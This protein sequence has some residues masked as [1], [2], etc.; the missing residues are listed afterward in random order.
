M[1]DQRAHKSIFFKDFSISFS[2]LP[3]DKKNFFYSSAKI[4]YSCIA[5][6]FI[7]LIL[8]FSANIRVIV[9]FFPRLSN[10]RDNNTKSWYGY[11]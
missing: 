3:V 4:L 11:K 6:I 5:S 9:K 2:V 7:F 8:I 10:S 1:N